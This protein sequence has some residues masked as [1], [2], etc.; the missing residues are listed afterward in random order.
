MEGLLGKIRDN[1][2]EGLRERERER[3][4]DVVVSA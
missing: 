4:R 2:E 1:P 3:E